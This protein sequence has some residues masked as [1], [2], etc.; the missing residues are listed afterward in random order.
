MN[1]YNFNENANILSALTTLRQF[2]QYTLFPVPNKVFDSPFL[3]KYFDSPL[4]AEIERKVEKI[5]SAAAIR[6]VY[7]NSNIPQ[8]RKET[9]ARKTVRDLCDALRNAK[10]EYHAQAKN[11]SHKE[12]MRRKRCIPLVSRIA[13]I[14][15]AKNLAKTMTFSAFATYIAGPIGGTMVFAS[16][17]IWRFLPDGVRES[18]TSA[19][20]EIKK[21][22]L[23]TAQSLSSYVKTTEAGTRIQKTIEKIK[24]LIDKEKKEFIIS[25]NRVKDRVKSYWPF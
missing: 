10:L 15:M 21:T 7:K 2:N 4:D 18:L 9:S 1:I 12:Y 6:T 11:L 13:K 8:E 25:I 24:P 23:D 19:T 22:A 16:R 14:K 17:V 3:L 20:K 5:I